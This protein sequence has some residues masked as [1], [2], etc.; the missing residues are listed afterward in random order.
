MSVLDTLQAELDEGQDVLRFYYPKASPSELIG[1]VK[2][3]R[4]FRYAKGRW[5][6][7]EE[8]HADIEREHRLAAAAAAE[9]AAADLQ[10]A[11]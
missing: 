11:G 1:R 10:K 3:W 5:P 2:Q 9:A 7:A 4:A 6:S 8:V